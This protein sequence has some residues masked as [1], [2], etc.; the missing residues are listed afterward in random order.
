MNKE[1]NL[2][3]LC[4]ACFDAC[5]RGVCAL[6]RLLGG[7]VRLTYRRWWIVLIVMVLAAA[8]AYWWQLPSR[9]EYKVEGT[10]LLNGPSYSHFENTYAELMY[11]NPFSATQNLMCLLG[12]DGATA[13][14]VYCFESYP[15]I[16]CMHDGMPDYVDYAHS[17]SFTDTML[18]HL[19][20]RAR[21]RFRLKGCVNALP[22]VEMALLRYFNARPDF[23]ASYARYRT[24]LERE[25]RFCHDQIEKLDSMTSAYYFRSSEAE[26]QSGVFS[27]ERKIVLPLKAIENHIRRTYMVDQRLSMAI[28]PVVIEDHLVLIPKALYDPVKL[29]LVTLLIGWLVGCLLAWIVEDRKKI[30][31]WLK[32]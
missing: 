13:R 24:T 28:A 31:A 3:D 2:W 12:I 9:R 6:L 21:I 27:G 22:E 1:T 5:K 8:T 4:V 25:H 10:L 15:V 29:A 17:A 7:M 30:I 18:I 19:Q 11:S 26:T 23:Q 14:R 16:D 20:D 32:R